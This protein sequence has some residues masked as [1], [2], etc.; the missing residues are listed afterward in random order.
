MILGVGLDQRLGFRLDEY[1]QLGLEAQAR[2]FESIWTHSMTIPDAFHACAAW[3][4][5]ATPGGTV[6]RTG[7]GVI[8]AL[9]SWKL[10]SLANQAATV[11]EI[12]G[13]KFVLGIGTGGAGSTYW[14]RIGLPNRPISVMRDYVRALRTLLETGSVDTAGT[15]LPPE[16]LH[17]ARPVPTVPVYLAALGP[18]MLRVA[19]AVANGVCLNWAT[20]DQIAW[21]D[22][23]ITRGAEA[24]GRGRDEVPMSM[25][26]RVCVDDDV[27]AARRAFGVQV[28]NYGLA[29]PGVDPSLS[30]RG[31]FGRMGFDD[32]FVDLEKRR[33]AG[34][35]VAELV[36]LV[37]D[38]LLLSVGY[39]GTAEGAATR[40]AEL[41][42]GL[43]E[44]I[45]RV[46]TTS[47]STES[48]VAT[49]DAL[50]PAKIRAHSS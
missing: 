9:R 43:D 23:Q 8:P 30:Y 12:S 22:E 16:E 31:H 41:A 3:S 34:T 37:P 6:P 47:R 38:E 20:P 18:Q 50:T 36:D 27:A 1:A 33:A 32:L 39:F 28:L 40:F 42:K 5:P 44:A 19:G 46:I 26:I 25:Y 17:L 48:V 10:E 7:V 11:S 13:G 15:A 29:R 45:V 4:N 35:P 21:S 14:E 24:A 49:M 2:G